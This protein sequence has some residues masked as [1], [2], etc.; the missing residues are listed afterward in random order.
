M[1]VYEITPSKILEKQG[2]VEILISTHLVNKDIFKNVLRDSEFQYLLNNI[3]GLHLHLIYDN[4]ALYIEGKTTPFLL[5]NSEFSRILQY[6]TINYKCEQSSGHNAPK[7]V[8]NK[9]F[10]GGQE[11]DKNT[12]TC[13]GVQGGSSQTIYQHM[14]GIGTDGHDAPIDYD[15]YERNRALLL[16]YPEWT[17][18]MNEMSI[19]SEHWKLLAENWTLISELYNQNETLCNQ[20][21]IELWNLSR[22]VSGNYICK[23][24]KIADIK[25]SSTVTIFEHM[26]T[27]KVNNCITPKNIDE[28]SDI[29]C[30]L[31]HFPE[32]NS[33]MG[34]IKNL[35]T[36][37]CSIV[38]SWTLLDKLRNQNADL[39]NALLTEL[40]K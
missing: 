25:Y 12:I 33:R 19:Y 22:K 14:A 34:E 18:R 27:G 26:K 31:R 15:D 6:L 20:L 28:L 40:N 21:L 38:D 17:S 13:T 36:Q 11:Y 3:Y 35:S 37:W 8:Y 5:S 29:F 1:E 2:K 9:K 4:E 30:M 7:F 39:C 23:P 16:C 24:Q 32:W 10:K